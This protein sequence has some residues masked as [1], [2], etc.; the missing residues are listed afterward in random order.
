MSVTLNR[1]I[2]SWY[3]E[4]DEQPWWRIDYPPIA[5]YISYLF[6]KTYKT[7]ESESMLIQRGY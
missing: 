5:A 1:S 6:G 2:T 7:I 3:E 4:N